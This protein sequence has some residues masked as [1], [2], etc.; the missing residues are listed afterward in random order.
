ML[1]NIFFVDSVKFEE[2]RIKK[3]IFLSFLSILSLTMSGQNLQVGFGWGL[4]NFKNNV[5]ER[6][7]FTQLSYKVDGDYRYSF[8]LKYQIPNENIR[9]HG[10]YYYA[11]ITG[12]GT[13]INLEPNT[14]TNPLNV[15]TNN[16]LVTIALGF[17]YFIEDKTFSPYAG[18][19]LLMGIFKDI[20][21]YYSNKNGRIV[22][23]I[24]PSK[25]RIGLGLNVGI[26]YEVFPG[27]NLDI[28]LLYSSLNF[29]GKKDFEENI[30]TTDLSVLLLF[31]L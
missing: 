3:L 12:T 24:Y 31:S 20:D 26:S 21:V 16:S 15:E 17:E 22:H 25:T 23:N 13:I 7:S 11:D 1:K 2:M 4:F 18:A 9:F 10:G 29:L 8:L 19:D 28:N 6:K 14:D 30:I 27:M 5:V